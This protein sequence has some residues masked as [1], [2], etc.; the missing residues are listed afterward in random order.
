MIEGWFTIILTSVA[1]FTG[2]TE[3][4]VFEVRMDD[5]TNL[6]T[7]KDAD[8]N[9]YVVIASLEIEED[10]L[11]TGRVFIVGAKR[12]ICKKYLG[13]WYKA[14]STT[15]TGKIKVEAFFTTDP[16]DS[17]KRLQKKPS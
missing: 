13:T 5:A 2:G 9:G 11:V 4:I 10:D 12:D 7:A 14:G 17:R 16:P 6:A 3:G 15:V 8:G 1:S